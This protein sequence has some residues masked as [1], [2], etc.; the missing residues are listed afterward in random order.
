M[1]Q[2]KGDH[3]P[4][5][6]LLQMLPAGLRGPVSRCFELHSSDRITLSEL[7]AALKAVRDGPTPAVPTAVTVST[8]ECRVQ[9][10]ICFS[11]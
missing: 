3:R 8:G 5:P 9:M 4:P 6:E 7:L 11:A 10:H 2:R 1:M